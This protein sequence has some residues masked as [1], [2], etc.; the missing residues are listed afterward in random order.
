MIKSKH[1]DYLSYAVSLLAM[2]AFLSME[3]IYVRSSVL[4]S[5]LDMASDSGLEL[6]LGT[7]LYFFGP[8][9][10]LLLIPFVFV[11]LIY[12]TFLTNRQGK[13]FKLY[14]VYIPLPIVGLTV[15]AEEYF[16]HRK[17][18]HIYQAVY[19]YHDNHTELVTNYESGWWITLAAL[20]YFLVAGVLMY[21]R[22]AVDKRDSSGSNTKS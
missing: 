14:M 11:I 21:W 10:S 19:L 8:N 13:R 22:I 12:A 16:R 4:M 20:I 5:S 6:A 9:P 2:F 3:W 17:N 1:V 15:F 7:G 18:I